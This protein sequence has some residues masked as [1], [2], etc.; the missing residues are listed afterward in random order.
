MKFYREYNKTFNVFW[1]ISEISCLIGFIKDLILL[2][3]Y[4]VA[5]F[6]LFSEINNNILFS[7]ITNNWILL[8]SILYFL[9]INYR[10]IWYWR[11][12]SKETR[13]EYG[14]L[15]EKKSSNDKTNLLLTIIFSFGFLLDLFI[16]ISSICL[17]ICFV[18]VCKNYNDNPP[19]YDFYERM[20]KEQQ[21]IS[22]EINRVQNI[23]NQNLQ[24]CE[25]VLSSIGTS[26]FIENFEVLKHYPSI[27]AIDNIKTNLPYDEKSRR[28]IIAKSLF[29]KNLGKIALEYIL[30]TKSTLLSERTITTVSGL[31][32]KYYN[33]LQY[34]FC[35]KCGQKLKYDSEFCTTCGTKQ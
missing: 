1:K 13:K 35:I 9:V 33:T 7:E 3:L 22:E 15:Y 27:D 4:C 12:L 14:E 20:Q 34:V 16:G 23:R 31:L 21:H 17:T 5:F 19:L 26:F 28:T 24:E 11:L 6:M 8:I 25:R 29:E 10:L 2:P 30:Q 32:E 18:I